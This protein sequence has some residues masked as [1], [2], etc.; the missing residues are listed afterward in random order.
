MKDFRNKV[1]AITGAGSGMGRALALELAA[2][3]CA[4]AIADVGLASLNETESMLRA[5]KVEGV[6]PSS[7]TLRTAPQ[8]SG[9]PKTSC[10]CTAK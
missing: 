5:T 4:V 6:E 2:R 1:A 3:G 9:S 10:A 8:W 7:W